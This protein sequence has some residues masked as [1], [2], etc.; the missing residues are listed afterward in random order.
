MLP[1]DC[2]DVK[3]PSWRADFSLFSNSVSELE[4]I[5]ISYFFTS[6][7]YDFKYY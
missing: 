6:F 2:L 5:Y 7:S 3:Q 1:Y 4:G